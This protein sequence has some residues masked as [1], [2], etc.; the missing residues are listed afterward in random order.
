MLTK[1]EKEELSALRYGFNVYK[2]EVDY[3]YD[4]S[5]KFEL[6]RPMSKKLLTWSSYLNI[7]TLMLFL[8]SLLITLFKP[9]PTYYA[10]TPNGKIYKLETIKLPK[11]GT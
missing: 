7:L 6:A 9:A 5:K 11:K 2:S 4:V 8:A 3:D 10:S 1:E